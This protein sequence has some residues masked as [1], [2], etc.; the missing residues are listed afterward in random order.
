MM[1]APQVRPNV[2]LPLTSPIPKGTSPYE[3]HCRLLVMEGYAGVGPGVWS[4]KPAMVG[5]ALA[6]R[7][8]GS[9]LP[10]WFTNEKSPIYDAIRK[11]AAS[12]PAA[13]RET[14]EDIVQEVISGLTRSNT[15]GGELY[16][17]GE[18][19]SESGKD[20]MNMAAHYLY[21]HARQRTLSAVRSRPVVT[22]DPPPA[23]MDYRESLDYAVWACGPQVWNAA[24]MYL[25][26]AWATCPSKIVIF[27]QIM[28]DVSKSDVQVAR[29]LGHG[30]ND[31]VSWVNFGM[32]AYVSKTRREIRDMMPAVVRKYPW[33]LDAS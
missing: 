31:P 17:V 1:L 22:P 9:T 13:N 5:W 14:Q 20:V 33:A 7:A 11:G 10:R 25:K 23:P 8:L 15:P 26:V 21:R 30:E 29:D 18:V 3:V 19:L 2:P 24:R 6:Q 32:A 4:R 12:V 28:K 27:E 16:A